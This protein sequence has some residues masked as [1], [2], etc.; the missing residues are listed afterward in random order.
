MLVDELMGSHL[1]YWVAQAE[2]RHT[3]IPM[4]G[5]AQPVRPGFQPIVRWRSRLSTVSA[6]SSG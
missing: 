4:Q 1:D 5:P 3:D 6:L 2:Q